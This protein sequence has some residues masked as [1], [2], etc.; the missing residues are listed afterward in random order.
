MEQTPSTEQKPKR[1]VIKFLGKIF[2]PVFRAGVKLLPGGGALVELVQNLFAEFRKT[3]KQHSYLSIVIQ[4]VGIS[5][6]IYAFITKQITIDQLLQ[7]LNSIP[8]A[9]PETSTN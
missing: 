7:L 1:K 6:I 4:V 9:L 3:E 8:N 5:A 2:R